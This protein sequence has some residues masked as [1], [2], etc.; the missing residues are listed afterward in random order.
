MSIPVTEIFVDNIVVKSGKEAFEDFYGNVRAKN[1]VD[2][3]ADYLKTWNR[4]KQLLFTGSF[5]CP[6]CLLTF[7]LRR[8]YEDHITDTESHANICLTTQQ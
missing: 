8:D 3:F 6:R 1:Y 7:T 5:F 4:Q 2:H